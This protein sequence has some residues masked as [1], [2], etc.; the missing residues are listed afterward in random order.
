M[1]KH[2]ALELHQVP[3]LHRVVEQ[4]QVEPAKMVLLRAIMEH[5]ALKAAE[6]EQVLK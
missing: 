6:V 2:Q 3:E 4:R 1:G 5:L